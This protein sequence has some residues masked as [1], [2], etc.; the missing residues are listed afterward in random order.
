MIS[1]HG[2]SSPKGAAV[3]M[4]LG[5]SLALKTDPVG[6]KEHLFIK[7]PTGDMIDG[8]APVAD[9]GAA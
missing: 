7:P 8:T 4:T 1:S 3:A 9:D 2:A 6:T 5:F